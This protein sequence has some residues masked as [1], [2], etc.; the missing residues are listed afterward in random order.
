M[1]G[2]PHWDNTTLWTVWKHL[3]TGGM[4]FKKK[5]V[6]ASENGKDPVYLTNYSFDNKDRTTK[7]AWETPPSNKSVLKGKPDNHRDYFFLPAMG[8]YASGKLKNFREYGLYWI[9]TPEPFFA[10]RAY[11]LF[12]NNKEA[13]LSNMSK[14]ENG[15]KLW[16]SQ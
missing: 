9:K 6:I 1:K 8:N 13:G 7:G 16:T 15:Y 12:F 2:K 14:R 11:N 3:Y 5:S 10:G 4:W